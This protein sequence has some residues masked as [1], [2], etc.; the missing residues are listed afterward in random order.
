MKKYKRHHYRERG[1]TTL[2]ALGAVII[3]C[4]ILFGMLQIYHWCM[5]RHFCQYAAFYACKSLALGFKPDLAMRAAR[6]AGIAISG[7][8]TGSGDNDE[9]AA[10]KYMTYGDVSGVRYE[11]WHGRTSANNPSLI[12]RLRYGEPEYQSAKVRLENLPLVS[13]GVAKMFFISSPPEPE[14]TVN[15]YNYSKELMED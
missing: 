3:L 6:V 5:N 7:E 13:P 2:E 14:A 9:A 11:Y 4:F 12:V 8:S 1:S 10:K 15:A